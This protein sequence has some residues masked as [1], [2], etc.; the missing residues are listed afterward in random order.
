MGLAVRNSEPIS[1]FGVWDFGVRVL[2]F[3]FWFSKV[4][5]SDPCGFGVWDFGRFRVWDSGLGFG[6][7]GVGSRDSFFV[8]WKLPYSDPCARAPPGGRPGP[9]RRSRASVLNT[10]SS[11]S[12]TLPSVSNTPPSVSHTLPSVSNTLPSVSH[13]LPS[14]SHTLPNVSDTLPSVSNTLPS[15]SDTLPSVSNTVRFSKVPYS[16]PCARA[17]PGGSSDLPR[18]SGT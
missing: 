13:T 8:F 4:P 9:P 6:I 12:M 5:Y 11:V 7:S 18:R 16:D 2:G 10:L 3:G 15:V 14:V 17:P 1:R